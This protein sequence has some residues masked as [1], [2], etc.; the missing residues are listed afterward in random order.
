MSKQAA[1][2]LL[3]V[4]WTETTALLALHAVPGLGPRSINGLV[5]QLGSAAA[6]AGSPELAVGV[7]KPKAFELLRRADLRELALEQLAGQKRCGA[8]LLVRGEAGYP[9]E[10]EHL[11][12][13]PPLVH[14][15][16]NVN[17]LG[18]GR[19]RIA[20]I[21]A[22]AC[23]AYGRSQAARFGTGLAFGG[24]VLVSGAARG[25]DQLAM[26]AAVQ[27]QGAVVAV[28]GSGLDRPYP[29][30]C[31]PLLQRLLDEGGA[32]VSEFPFGAGPRAGNFPRR[33]RLIA[34]L[35]KAVLVIQ[36]TRKSGTMNT[37]GWALQLGR[38]VFALPGPVDD[39][40]CNGTN[41]MIHDGAGIA[42]GPEE[43][44]MDLN[45]TSLALG[46]SQEPRVLELLQQQDMFPIEL[47]RESGIEEELVRMQLLD[48][49]L[50]GQVIRLSSGHYHRCGPN[51]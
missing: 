24:E 38:E 50:R 51:P 7:I 6:V 16:G 5:E 13:P 21:G 8:S 22:R 32:V 19:S 10:F 43:M 20:V 35:S 14:V 49:E 31:W 44:L 4:E 9:E 40:A 39:I 2:R 26:G 34:A 46:Q 23:T 45:N 29:K 11:E 36:A 1:N 30:D 48:F 47:A 27:S 3:H 17:L 37:V 33:N 25:I 41:I 42:L 18:A 12:A 15:L 28:V